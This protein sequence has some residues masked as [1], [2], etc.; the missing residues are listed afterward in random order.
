MPDTAID[1]KGHK[2]TLLMRGT[3]EKIT[4]WLGE[5]FVAVVQYGDKDKMMYD[6]IPDSTHPG[7]VDSLPQVQ[8]FDDRGQALAHFMNLDHNKKKWK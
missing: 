4:G 2:A 5:I 6:V 1:Y 8:T 3:K 7:D